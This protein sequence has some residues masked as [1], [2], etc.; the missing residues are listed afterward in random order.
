[1]HG[2]LNQ[3][4]VDSILGYMSSVPTFAHDGAAYGM[5]DFSNGGKWMVTGGW[6]RE[7]GHYRAGLNS[8]PVIERFRAF[9]DDFFLARVGIAGIMSVLPNIDADGAPSMGWHT[10]PFI[11]AHDA[12]SGDYGLAF[13]GSALNMG[14]YVVNDT[15][16]N[17]LLCYMCSYSRQAGGNITFRPTDAFHRRVYYA[18]LGLWL[19][20]EAG[21]LQS[22]TVSDAAHT[23][24]V[25]FEPMAVV[26]AAA[27]MGS[28]PFDLLRLRFEQAAPTV[29]PFAFTLA[30]PTNAQLIRGAYA[31]EPAP[32]AANTTVAVIAWS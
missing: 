28:P 6:E 16:V 5:G 29:R 21:L 8:I 15:D 10:H 20:S 11:M 27:G 2:N 4:T 25:V 26:Q 32:N 13:F 14:A 3:R 24:T 31:F 1:M 23:V 12:H 22:V 19:V 17:D 18:P 30:E 7:G 9:P